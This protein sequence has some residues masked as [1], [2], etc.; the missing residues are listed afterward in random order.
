MRKALLILLSFGV[1]V[2]T[3][4]GV[5]AS[6]DCQRWVSDYKLALAQQASA[7]KLLAEKRRARAYAH[8]RLSQLT[9]GKSPTAH[10][11]RIA[12]TRPH[13]TPAQMVKRFELLCG[14]LPMEPQVLDARMAPDD[15]V[16]EMSLG[17][18]VEV[19]D[20]SPDDLLAE[21]ALPAY[22]GPGVAGTVPSSGADVAPFGPVYGSG[23]RGG[24]PGS[25]PPAPPPVGPEIP[26]AATPEPSSL[27][28]LAT[29]SLG[30][31]MVMR[32]RLA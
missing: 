27:L 26:I 5:S 11:T 25:L 6:T 32:R 4:R 9:S 23:P 21:N 13:L 3:V 24:A 29:G 15:F 18:P 8:R 17:G 16:S 20:V 10:P 2:A 12:S 7:Q 14:D 31:L 19:G 1:V 22:D 30:A 28:L